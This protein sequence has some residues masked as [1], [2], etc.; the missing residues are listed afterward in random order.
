MNK[1]FQIYIGTPSPFEL[2]CMAKTKEMFDTYILFSDDIEGGF[3]LSGIE[4][5]VKRSRI[6]S[7]LYEMAD[8]PTQKSDILRYVFLAENTDYWY[9]DCD[10]TLEEFPEI[11]GNRPY[12]AEFRNGA[13]GFI[14]FGNNNK[15]VFNL[16]IQDIFSKV[17]RGKGLAIS[18]YKSVKKQPI[19]ISK[20]YFKHKG[21]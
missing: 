3:P 10:A 7:F 16:I 17:K 12:F 4:K 2:E 18:P 21:L 14:I 13:D 19:T 9:L 20:T 1:V 5:A 11:T 6:G 15:S 8:T